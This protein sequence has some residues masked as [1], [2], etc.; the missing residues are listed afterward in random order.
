MKNRV[1]FPCRFF[2]ITFAWSWITWTPLL[3]GSQGIITVSD[4]LLSTLVLPSIVLGA[5]GPL[6]GALAALRMEKGKGFSVKYLKS[7]LDLKSGWKAWVIP[8]IIFGGSTFVAWILPELYGEKRLSILLPSIWIYFPCLLFMTFLGGG[9]EE[10]GW[11]GYALPILEDKFGIWIA[12]AILGIIWASWH[13]PLWFM[14]GPSQAYMNFGGFILLMVGYSYIFS[15]VRKIS[16]NRPFSVIYAHGL[17]NS[18]ISIM[19]TL[20]MKEDVPQPRYWIWVTLTFA[21]GIVVT[22]LR[23]KES[24]SQPGQDE[25][26]LAQT[27]PINLQPQQ[28][29]NNISI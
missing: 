2:L 4:K 1:N 28:Q 21:A 22:F 29:T 15:W 16:G 13:A 8:I 5:F 7:F 3:L 25:S 9:Q 17:A 12:N 23:K 11:R 26:F 6:A 27:S 18:L 20:I 10:F 14:T 24:L 19:P